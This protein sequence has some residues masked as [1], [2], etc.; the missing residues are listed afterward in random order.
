MQYNHKAA[1]LDTTV[2]QDDINSLEIFEIINIITS[3]DEERLKILLPRINLDPLR[4]DFTSLNAQ[5]IKNIIEQ[6][7]KIQDA[8]VIEQLK[9]II[10]HVT[11]GKI[12][13]GF[14]NMQ[15]E[16]SSNIAEALEDIDY[17]S[18][19]IPLKYSLTENINYL[20]VFDAFINPGGY[21]S[22]NEYGETNIS[23]LKNNKLEEHEQSYQSV[24]NFAKQHNKPY[25]GICNGAQHLVLNEGGSVSVVK[26]ESDEI[27]LEPGSIVHFFAMDLDEQS[28]ALQYHIFP[29]IQ[30]YIS[31][32]HSYAGVSDKLGN[33]Q[34]GGLSLTG[35]VEAVARNF[36]QLGFQFH[37]ENRY[38]LDTRNF[39]LLDNVFRIFSAAK[40]TDM[41]CMDEYMSRELDDAFSQAQCCFDD[42]YYNF[43]TLFLRDILREAIHACSIEDL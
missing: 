4:P 39:N 33:V 14:N 12:L 22:F 21:D 40:T 31:I 13:I 9:L 5:S 25:L 32:A 30:F 29:E 20:S 1:Y 19:V 36:Y 11:D 18:L 7:A 37:P 27:I 34:L 42:L 15:G 6:I 43:T 23:Y 16:W 17:A 41:T 8:E 10:E 26:A 38:T 28:I 24:I 2:Q 3:V 35:V